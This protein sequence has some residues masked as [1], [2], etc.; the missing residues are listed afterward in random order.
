MY[1]SDLESTYHANGWVV[2]VR[3]HMTPS[4]NSCYE[5]GE[6]TTGSVKENVWSV[7]KQGHVRKAHSSPCLGNERKTSRFI[8]WRQRG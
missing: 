4:K 1:P 8:C 5:I 7:G 6:R 3:H 2:Y